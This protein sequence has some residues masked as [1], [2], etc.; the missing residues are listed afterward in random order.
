MHGGVIHWHGD[1]SRRD[2]FG[3]E[4]GKFSFGMCE[5]VCVISKMEQF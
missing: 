2:G 3:K 1:E 5:L 4:D